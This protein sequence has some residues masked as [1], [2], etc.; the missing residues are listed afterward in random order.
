MSNTAINRFEWLKA[1]TQDGNLLP[2][3]KVVATALSVQFTDDKTGQL[4][5]KVTT[6]ADY[7][8]V[9]MATL[10]RAIR[11]LVDAGWLGK[12]R[13]PGPGKPHLLHPAFA[14]QNHSVFVPK[15]RGHR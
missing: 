6:L 1:V 9:S 14:R 4:N 2:M 5:P 12:N 8:K 13:G 7:V 15:E 11:A 10:K 3:A